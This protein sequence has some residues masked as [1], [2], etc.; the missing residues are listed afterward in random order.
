MINLSKRLR[1]VA[2]MVTPGGGAVD[3]GT[4]HAYIPIYLAKNGLKEHVYACDVNK[5]P[6]AIAESNIAEQ[7]CSGVV[8][9]CLCNGLSKVLVSPGDSVIIAGMGGLLI[10]DILSRD[11][12]KAKT[13]GELILQPQS[14]FGKLRDYLCNAGFKITDE[15]AVTE[16]GKYYFAIKAVVSHDEDYSLTEEEKEFGPLLLSKKHPV[17]K[18]YLGKCLGVEKD[19]MARLSKEKAGENVRRRMRQV[20]DRISFLERVL[21]GIYEV[22]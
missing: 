3:I 5:G 1:M 11:I 8:E 9:T 18:D 12:D 10:K 4:D 7:G 15:D 21:E 16:E 22:Q 17:M 13:A 6:I 19:I 2:D 20:T 14:E